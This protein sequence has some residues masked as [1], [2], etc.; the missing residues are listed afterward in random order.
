MDDL[1]NGVS[2]VEDLF[3]MWKNA[4]KHEKDYLE[5]TY[6]N[7]EYPE[8]NIEQDSF[9][10]DGYIDKNLYEKSPIKV[11]FILKEANIANPNYRDKSVNPAE[12]T[13]Y[14]FYRQYISKGDNLNSP[15]QQEKM[16]RMAFYLQHITSDERLK[17]PSD[18]EIKTALS[19]CA[20][21][22][23]NKRGGD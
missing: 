10:A 5:T 7:D 21:M 11:L 14:N 16:G 19:K 20:F 2:S 3:A 13:Q 17:N 15:K 9:N 18:E 8:W 12:R 4:H 23:L 6:T 1:L 22:N